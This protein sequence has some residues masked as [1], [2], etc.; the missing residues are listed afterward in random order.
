MGKF[1]ELR[2]W[3]DSMDLTVKIY[4]ITRELPFNKDFGLCN[5][6]RKAASSIASNIAEGDER[7]TNRESV[8]FFNIAKGSTAEVITQLNIAFRI[9]YIDES[10]LLSL[11]NQADKVLASLKNL[12]KSRGGSNP[13]NLLIW[14]FI[15]LTKPF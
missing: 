9:G 10:T 11:E 7:G 8:H 5:Q 15:S 14:F 3:N 6:I 12:I 4:E 13:L 2:V 1:K